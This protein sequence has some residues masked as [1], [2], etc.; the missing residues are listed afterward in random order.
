[1]Q[2]SG[3]A[4][5][6]AALYARV[7]TRD[8]DQDPEVQLR[9]LREWAQRQGFESVEYI[10]HASGKDLNRPGWLA[11]MAEVKRSRIDVIAV[12]RLDRAFRSV[13]DMSMTLQALGVR[14]VRFAAATQDL[15]TGTATGKLLVN[16][17]GSFGEFERDI[18][19]ERI[20]EG[21]ARARAEGKRIGRRRAPYS[22]KR[23]SAMVEEYGVRETAYRL[24]LAPSTV[25][26]RVAKTKGDI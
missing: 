16:L 12:L 15:D 26:R 7:S 24:Q 5:K 8:K 10:D 18:A 4:P 9:I 23:I 25:S 3:V 14:G 6:R 19:S 20:K 2:L 11:M 21:Q 1:M 17:L 13:L 22:D